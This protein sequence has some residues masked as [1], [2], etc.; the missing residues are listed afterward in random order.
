MTTS[1]SDSTLPNELDHVPYSPRSS[2]YI[3]TQSSTE[4][5]S[6]STP[7]HLLNK[8]YFNLQYFEQYQYI[9][10]I[11]WKKKKKKKKLLKCSTVIHPKKLLYVF[12]QIFKWWRAVEN[13]CEDPPLTRIMVGQ[14]SIHI[15]PV[16]SF[17]TA[18]YDLWYFSANWGFKHLRYVTIIYICSIQIICCVFWVV[19]ERHVSFIT[20][21]EKTTSRVLTDDDQSLTSWWLLIS[22]VYKSCAVF[23]G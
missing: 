13:I 16:G 10:L 8:Y 2:N 3:S 5:P 9:L 22:A 20:H 14:M 1:S 7:L 12:C 17:C 4:T 6:L 11:M 23:S 21:D 18:P 15:S 19:N